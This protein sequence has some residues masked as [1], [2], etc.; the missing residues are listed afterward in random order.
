KPDGVGRYKADITITVSDNKLAGVPAGVYK[1][2]ETANVV[3]NDISAYLGIDKTSGDNVTKVYGDTYRFV[4]MTSVPG[5][6]IVK[7][8]DLKYTITS[9]ANGS[10]KYF[11]TDYINAE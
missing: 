5:E 9:T 2:S 10:S 8:D 6:F 1:V 7:M 3:K 11:Y 4:G